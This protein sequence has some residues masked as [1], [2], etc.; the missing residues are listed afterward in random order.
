MSNVE[1]ARN[2]E[3]F[4]G[5]VYQQHENQNNWVVTIRFYSLLHY[6]E[7]KLQSHNYNSETHGDRKENI[8][9]CKHVDNRVRNLYRRLEDISRDARYE[10]IEMQEQDVEMSEETLNEAK[11][12]LGFT[13]G[14]GS[15]KYST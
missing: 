14:G 12:V 5:E 1:F 7:Q 8:R 3:D 15:T 10:C 11:E 2:N 13:S 6:V 4:A 9:N